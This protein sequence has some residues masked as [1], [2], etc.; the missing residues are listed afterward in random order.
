MSAWGY[1]AF[2]NDVAADL[3]LIWDEYVVPLL[4][5]SKEDKHLICDRFFFSVFF[6]E[7]INH[8]DQDTNIQLIAIGKLYFD[9]EITISN[10][11]KELIERAVYEEKKADALSCWNDPKKRR[12]WL[13]KFVKSIGGRLL[14][15][16]DLQIEQNHEDEIKELKNFVKYLKVFCG[17]QSPK[18]VGDFKFD[19]EFFEKYKLTT[20]DQLELALL[21]G[22]KGGA[23][24]KTDEEWELL[25]LRSI[26]L[27]YLVGL[28][29]EL[30]SND[31]YS[32]CLKAKKNEIGTLGIEL[33]GSS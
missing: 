12:E 30:S 5:V 14:K 31:L 7:K 2:E 15:K 6:R 1:T 32:L 22:I 4:K 33:F 19:Y 11:F 20:K 18:E 9:S 10:S 25:Q 29:L 23:F 24:S 17:T 28:T 21:E 16:K 27:A 13:N 3:I 8:E 26:V